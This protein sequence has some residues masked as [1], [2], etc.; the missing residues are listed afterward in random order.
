[1]NRQGN[2]RSPRV[3]C[4]PKMK[5]LIENNGSALRQ[6]AQRK[7]RRMRLRA[8]ITIQ[9]NKRW[10]SDK[11]RREDQKS[12]RQH[13]SDTLLSLRSGRGAFT[14]AV[15]QQRFGTLDAPS[16]K[17]HSQCGR[18]RTLMGC[19]A[20]GWRRTPK[21][22]VQHLNKT[23]YSS[24]IWLKSL[25]LTFWTWDNGLFPQTTT[26]KIEISKRGKSE[27]RKRVKQRSQTENRWGWRV[28]KRVESSI[29]G[30][31]W[32]AALMAALLQ[33]SHLLFAALRLRVSWLLCLA[34]TSS[35]NCRVCA[36]HS[37]LSGPE[38]Y[39]FHK[40]HLFCGDLQTGALR[41]CV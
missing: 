9:Q 8:L 21:I 41:P 24:Q 1:M 15:R 4:V 37:G 39:G 33:Q 23:D 10:D 19:S 16:S 6:M 28:G 5:S 17:L 2:R 34:Q 32:A 29:S 20:H 22:L 12:V 27:K 40:H 36:H 18:D 31:G 11:C 3:S 13:G 35:S 7:R 25:D 38:N 26:K 14:P 30:G